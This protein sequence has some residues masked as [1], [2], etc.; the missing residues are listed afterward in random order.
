MTPPG[1]ETTRTSRRRFEQHR[2]RWSSYGQ[3]T[4]IA[5]ISDKPSAVTLRPI[6]LFADL[7]DRFLETLSPDLS[8]VEWHPGVVLFE[9]GS[10]IDLAFYVLEGEVEIFFEGGAEGTLSDD[11][12]RSRAIP[13]FDAE[14]TSGLD[15]TSL[16]AHS[17]AGGGSPQMTEGPRGLDTQLLDRATFDTELQSQSIGFLASVDI[18][19]GPGRRRRLGQG[20]LFGEIGAMSGWPQSVTARTVGPCRLLQIRVPA[21]RLLKRRSKG[22]KTRLDQLYRDR[23][24]HHQLQSTPLFRSLADDLL[25]RLEE[26][27]ELVSLSPGEVL[28]NE[29]DPAE[30]LYVV[31]S[32]FLKLSQ[33][34][35]EGEL[36]V[37]YL[38]KGMTLGEVELLI[39]GITGYEVTVTSVE[40]AELI[41]L[42]AATLRP[43]L[44]S[45][46]RLLEGLWRAVV[47]RLQEI[48]SSRRDPGRS[49]FI[50]SA[51]ETGLV[52]GNSILMIDLDLCTRCDDC[53][54]A[55]AATHGGRPRFVREGERLGDFLI[56]RSCYH[57]RDPVCL[58]G[59]PTG[60]IHRS[61]TS[62]VIDITDEICIGC[63]TCANNCPYDAIVMHETGETWPDDML[64]ASLRGE[65]RLVA[66]KCDLCSNAGHDPACVSHC[67]QGCA[68]RLSSV[69]E[70]R[71]LLEEHGDDPP[72]G[73]AGGGQ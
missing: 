34:Y 3:Q 30:T 71:H 33:R 50:Q 40:F 26:A 13:I 45:E 52:Q 55:C 37:T 6:E 38:S 65:D 63:A 17:A 29:H 54:R 28:L 48:G 9:Q 2:D 4:G 53:V 60:A 68:F 20:E 41:A 72:N 51:L 15:L 21:L 62:D 7:D 23:A 43:L 46:P 31:R 32:G 1:P 42:P 19:L 61:G 8:L 14:R 35:G 16:R 25:R 58:V 49:G 39:D 24:L 12:E 5:S 70:I 59:C 73:P 22:L 36:V 44:Q 10:Y 67:P 64:P 69:D 27:V 56:P 11:L 18:P 57:C 66:S 47:G